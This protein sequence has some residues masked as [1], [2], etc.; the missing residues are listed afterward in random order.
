MKYKKSFLIICL[1]ISLISIAGVSASEIADDISDDQL[2]KDSDGALQSPEE[3][4]QQLSSSEDY[5]LDQSEDDSKSASQK[6]ILLESESTD[7][8]NG[9]FTALQNKI[10]A[11]SEGDTITLE[12]DYTYDEGFSTTGIQIRKDITIN[13]NG[14]TI[15]GLSKSRIFLIH[16]GLIENNKVTLKNLK[17]INAK[18]DFYGGAIFNYANLTV[19]NC[20]FKNNYA[21]YCGGALLTVGAL[22]LKNSYFK[23]NT[24]G[25]DAGAVFSFKINKPLDLFEALYGEKAIIG[26]IETIINAIRNLTLDFGTDY[27]TNCTFTGNTAQGRG[28]GAVYAFSHISIKGSNFSSNKAGEHGGAV[29]ANKNI[30]VKN[31]KFTSN[32]APMSGGAV[33]FRCHELGG[34]YV[35]GSWVSKTIYYSASIQN[36]QFSK[37]SANK[38]GGAIYGFVE[39]SSDKKR[40]KVNKCNFTDNKAPTGRD[41]LGGTCTNCIF[42]YVKIS[43]KAVTVKKT[44]KKFVLTAT[45]T[46]G[47]KKIK[48]KKVSFRFYGKTYTAKTNSKGVAKVTIG[49][50]VIKK[51][52]AGKSYAVKITYLKTSVKT[53]VKVKK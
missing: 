5:I 51:L 17:L 36:S 53:S 2:I 16:Y 7:D 1:I 33:Y 27:I 39:K 21:K 18:T 37:N 12:R 26:E 29:F 23:N 45:F 50:S 42:Y 30:T 4:S 35:N 31:S 3:S 6:N 14:H 40:L 15:N 9:T 19:N 47:T 10:D 48:S 34:K 22:N 20:T 32:K 8:D 11:A 28:G 13:G 38:K 41:V 25:G 24:A 49:K 52:K 43:T 46:N 44:A